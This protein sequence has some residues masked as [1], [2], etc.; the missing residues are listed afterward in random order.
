MCAAVMAGRAWGG[1]L[2]VWGAA[3]CGGGVE[4]RLDVRGAYVDLFKAGGAALLPISSVSGEVARLGL[5]FESHQQHPVLQQRRNTYSACWR[6]EGCTD[7]RFACAHFL[8]A[9]QMWWRP[10]RHQVPRQF[11]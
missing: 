7:G 3:G 8:Y 11:P 6:G 1:G 2:G 4:L 5:L 9:Q 10:R